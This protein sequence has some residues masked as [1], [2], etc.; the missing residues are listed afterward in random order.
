VNGGRY[1][2]VNE[3]RR[4][5]SIGAGDLKSVATLPFRSTM[6]AFRLHLFATGFLFTLTAASTVHAETTA[7]PAP[8]AATSAASAPN[9]AAMM[10]GTTLAYR[11]PGSPFAGPQADLSPLVGF[12]RFLSPKIAL[13]LDAGPTFV[14]RK[15]A[16]FSL[17]PGIVWAFHP[18]V[19]AAGRCMVL[20]HP[21]A[22]LAVAPG[23][24]LTYA[25]QTES[26]PSRS[27]TK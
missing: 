25:S 12:G 13:E 23:L 19:Y 16:S 9:Y 27:S 7:P 11:A 3:G 22:N 20:V 26:L 15:Y 24:G 1:G 17:V 6:K 10:L 8:P 21:Q 18:N 14:G 5:R 2:E 4:S